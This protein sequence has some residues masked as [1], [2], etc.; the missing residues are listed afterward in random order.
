[1]NVVIGDIHG[2]VTKLKELIDNVFNIYNNPTIIF[3]G[4]YLD[5]GEDVYGTLEYIEILLE[6]YSVKLLY[7]N[8]EYF[9][10]KLIEDGVKNVNIE[11]YLIKYGGVMTLKSFNVNDVFVA[12]NIMLSKFPWFF[13]C[14]IPHMMVEDYLIT[15]SGIKPDDFDKE[16]N[17]IK[18]ENKLFNRY[19]FIETTKLYRNK[20]KIIFGHTGFLTPYIDKTKIGIDT[21]ACFLKEQPLTAFCVEDKIFIDSNG[22]VKKMNNIPLNMSPIIPRNKPWRYDKFINK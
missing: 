9:W 19:S 2:E 18:L 8:H 4:D 16:I 21:A 15:H 13:D 6:K 20:Y 12:R 3:I 1:M 14:L 10:E 22:V 17:E 7:G 5:K 11:K